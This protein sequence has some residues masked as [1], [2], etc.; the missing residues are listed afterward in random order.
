MS[1]MT[2]PGGLFK[3]ATKTKAK[4]RLALC[5]PA[6]SGKTL[7]ALLLAKGL[8]GTVF[9]VDTE[10]GSA[11]KYADSTEFGVPEFFT[12]EPTSF[13]PTAYVEMIKAAEEAGADVLIIDSLSHAWMGKDGALEQ[14]D[15][16]AK[17]SQTGNSFAAWRDVT[18]MHNQMVDAIL[19][20]NMHV[21]ATM[22]S[23]MEY[24]LEEDSRGKKVPRKVGMAPIQRD[25]LEY[26]FD[27]VGDMN[28]ANEL[29]VTKS[30]CPALSGAVLTKPGEDLAATLKE[31]LSSGATPPPK[32]P[33]AEEVTAGLVKQIAEALETWP[34]E[35]RDE[36]VVWAS[37]KEKD[38]KTF[39]FKGVDDVLASKPIR[40]A[41][42]EYTLGRLNERIRE[43]QAGVGQEGAAA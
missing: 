30:R 14:V 33:T 22:R 43:V 36:A 5:G 8:G 35:S 31:W 7:T 1:T 38:G 32:P 16:A 21:I 9:V 25:G 20:C 29:V 27:L 6:G 41:W 34:V 24:V 28:I 40:I 12:C 2:Q 15:R 42:L 10:R 26:E 23:K 18:P 11:S 4:L 19:G 37:T 17:R 39:S 3:R 13:S